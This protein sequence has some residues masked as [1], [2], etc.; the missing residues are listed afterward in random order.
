MF[1]LSYIGNA[2]IFLR[3]A[4]ERAAALESVIENE[5]DGFGVLHLPP[6]VPGE[7]PV[8]GRSRFA[9]ILHHAAQVGQAGIVG[10]DVEVAAKNH[11]IPF[12]IHVADALNHHGEPVAAGGFAHMVEMSVHE[13]EMLPGEFVLQKRP[14]GG[15]LAGGIPAERGHVR[16]FAEPV[17]APFLE[18]H[19]L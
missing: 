6:V 12:R 2:E 10:I 17:G 1:P 9:G 4:G 13:V 14:G 7:A 5:V 16:S 18:F 11:G 19:P 15:A 3:D 8:G